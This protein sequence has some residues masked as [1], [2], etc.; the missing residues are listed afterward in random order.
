[1]RVSEPRFYV[2]LATLVL[3]L[4]AAPTTYILA[5]EEEP[6]G[7]ATTYLNPSHKGTSWDSGS[8]SEECD[9]GDVVAD[10]VWHF[11][12]TNTAGY[13]DS[14]DPTQTLTATF[15]NAGEQQAV[16]VYNSGEGKNENQ[17][18]HF[19]IGTDTPE[20]LLDASVVPG[21]DDKANL[22]LSHVCYDEP[23]P[24]LRTITYTK[25]WEG[26]EFDTDVVVT[27]DAILGGEAVTLADGEESE[28]FEGDYELVGENVT[29]LP[30]NCEYENTAGSS[31]ISM[32]ED[33]IERISQTVVNTLDCEPEPEPEPTPE[34][35]PDPTPEPEPEPE[36]EPSPEPEPE[37]EPTPTPVTVERELPKTGPA[38][39]AA[40]ALAGLGSIGAGI[41]TLRRR[42]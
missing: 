30:E 25:V 21:G 40:L 14:D 34:P 32:G 13:F 17:A 10:V 18:I 1:M 33:G 36:P 42:R 23:D 22:N 39:V 27:F 16:G 20:T 26:D 6:T 3:L 12:L 4:L 7:D 24:E 19:Y 38:G 41:A 2:A 37:P 28:P 5:A 29:G 31:S 15:E 8:T 35:T 9:R 11:I